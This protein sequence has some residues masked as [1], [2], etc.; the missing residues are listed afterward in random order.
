[1]NQTPANI[2]TRTPASAANAGLPG[3]QRPRSLLDLMADGFYLLML[4]KR[5]QLPTDTERFVA[6]VQAFLDKIERSATKQGIAAEDIYAA[7]Y[8]FCAAVDEAVLSQVSPL[9]DEWERNPLQLRMFG[10]HLA[11]EHFFDRLEDLRS[12]GAPRLPSLEVYHYCL[13]LG[14]EGKYRLEGL[15]KLGFLTARLGDEIALLKG[16]RLGFAPHWAP[17]DTVAHA[18]RRV[19]PL[20]APAVL[21]AVVGGL[22]YLGFGTVLGRQTDQQLAAYQ[23]VVQLPARSAHVTITLP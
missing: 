23:D 7:K 10:E 9:R 1:M 3:A 19:V 21:L 22:A 13:L 14:F 4:L 15:E 17:P 5:G 11:G 6:S 20:W 18:L 2:S 8:A 16:K 12:Q